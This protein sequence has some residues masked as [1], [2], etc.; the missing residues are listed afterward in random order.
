MLHDLIIELEK[1]K[2]NKNKKEGNV[3][4]VSLI[5]KIKNPTLS[6][7]VKKELK[8]SYKGLATDML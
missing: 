5:C 8:Q 4:F 3:K 6:I 7:Y 2:K 1:N